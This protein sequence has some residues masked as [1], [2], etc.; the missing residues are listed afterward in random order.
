MSNTFPPPYDEECTFCK[1]PPGIPCR[2]RRYDEYLE[3]GV[4]EVHLLP[5]AQRAALSEHHSASTTGGHP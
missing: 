5:H 4:G 1:A 2:T 3:Y